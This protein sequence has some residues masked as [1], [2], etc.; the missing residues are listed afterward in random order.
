MGA[1]LFGLA[2]ARASATLFTAVENFPAAP[3]DMPGDPDRPFI[4]GQPPSSAATPKPPA[5]GT[6][7]PRE[8]L[9]AEFQNILVRLAQ[10]HGS[11]LH[12]NVTDAEWVAISVDS[13]GAAEL[14]RQMQNE[15]N[16]LF[17]AAD[18]RMQVIQANSGQVYLHL[19]SEPVWGTRMAMSK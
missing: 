13:V 11:A 12:V 10:K 19:L 1:P 14:G 15:R 2:A 4:L 9:P 3:N 16:V 8:L 17:G 6:Q 5:V 18:S 7:L